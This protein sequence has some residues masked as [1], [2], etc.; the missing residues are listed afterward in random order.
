MGN[1]SGDPIRWALCG[2]DRFGQPCTGARVGGTDRCLPHQLP[3]D[4]R[5]LLRKVAGGGELDLRGV[6]LSGAFLKEILTALDR[7]LPAARFDRVVFEHDADFADVVFLREAYFPGAH[8]VGGAEFSAASFRTSA[9]FKDV[10]FGDDVDF[11]NLRCSGLLDLTGARFEKA[12]DL[13][14]FAARTLVLDGAVFERHV[15]IAVVGH[16]ITCRRTA[17]GAGM[18]LHVRHADVVLTGTALGAP[19]SV[20]GAPR[21]LPAY[22]PAGRPSTGPGAP[23][24]PRVCSLRGVD[25]SR[26]ALANVNM[27]KCEFSGAYHLDQLRLEGMCPFGEPP[28]GLRKGRV[29]PHLWWWSRRQV[30]AEERAWRSTTRRSSGW[31]ATP[32]AGGIQPE[33]LAATYRALRKTQEDAKFEPG[34]ADFYYGEMEMRCR[35]RSTRRPE[36]VILRLYW[37]C[38]GYGL[39]AGRSLAGLTLVLAATVLTLVGT[40]LPATSGQQRLNGVVTP[41]RFDATISPVPDA[42]SRLRDRWTM[43]RV[44]QATR[45]ALGSVVFRDSSQSLTPLGSWIILLAKLLGPILLAL[46]FLGVRARVKR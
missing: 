18:T 32:G 6:R 14:S 31:P 38:S 15:T 29:F 10:V 20:V 9:S 8:F 33:D 7:V 21:A 13:G 44:D 34:A 4:R 40:G 24:M 3:E 45:I 16:Q 12:D 23:W 11:E 28:R 39:K 17:F 22:E 35:S 36:R 5:R 19:S 43:S 30:V 42:S 26:L 2:A 46:T 27:A 1:V 37:L 25:A 41:T